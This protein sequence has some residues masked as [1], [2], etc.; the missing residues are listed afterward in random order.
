MSFLALFNAFAMRGCL[1]I[2]ITEMVVTPE[3]QK[4]SVV[5][6]NDACAYDDDSLD[7]YNLSVSNHYP[8]KELYDWDEYTQVI[9]Y[10]TLITFFLSVLV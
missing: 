5:I 3:V 10:Q 1:N 6:D 7:L 9:F 4:S 8:G 2:A